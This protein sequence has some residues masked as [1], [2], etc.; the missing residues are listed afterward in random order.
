MVYDKNA[1]HPPITFREYQIL[2]LMATGTPN[3]EIADSL[4]IASNTV[5][6]HR[7]N[8]R[9][10]LGIKETTAR[11]VVMYQQEVVRLQPFFE[12]KGDDLE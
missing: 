1:E 4:F 8:I 11:R 12:S 5:R 7:R 10:K 9:I 2:K 6:T 3:E